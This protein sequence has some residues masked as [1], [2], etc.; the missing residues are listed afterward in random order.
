MLASHDESLINISTAEPKTRKSQEASAEELEDGSNQPRRAATGTASQGSFVVKP[1]KRRFF[2]LFIFCLVT[3]VSGFHW[4]QYSSIAHVATRYYS[5]SNLAMNWMST[6]Y[7]VTFVAFSLPAIL[8]CEQVG[9]RASVLNGATLMSA[10][11]AIKY[12]SASPNAF[13]RLLI[14]QTI[15]ALGQIFLLSVPPRLASVWFPDERVSAATAFG[16]FGNQFGVALGFALPPLFLAAAGDNTRRG[17]DYLNEATT[18]ASLA[19]L[20]LTLAFFKEAPQHAPGLARHAQLEAEKEMRRQQHHQ[21]ALTRLKEFAGELL[22]LARNKGFLALLV[23]YGMVVGTSYAPLTILSQLLRPLFAS[24]MGGQVST[25]ADAVVGFVGL[26]IIVSGML[27]ALAFAA[28]LDA[29]H[30]FKELS[31]T[32]LAAT[33]G[34]TLALGAGLELRCVSLV[35]A[36]SAALGFFVTGYLAIGFE[37]AVEIC[38]PQPEL[39]L[40]CLMNLT[41]QIFGFA[42]TNCASMVV[43]ALGTVAVTGLFGTFFAL[44]L[45]V[46]AFTELELRRQRAIRKLNDI[47][48]ASS[49]HAAAFAFVSAPASAGVGRA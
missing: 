2:V 48:S 15:T 6:V 5:V 4:I 40:A 37:V 20:V 17:L 10:G 33:L 25:N 31:V 21:S 1:S 9:L 18:L 23:A 11:A 3:M 19:T 16:V 27:G 49:R 35:C 30:R 32:L 36:S 41:P 39:L 42:I 47:T 22:A 8:W 24:G 7:M 44:G 38:Y 13:T 34:A 46:T 28:V 12:L 26:L 29:T 14:G 45:L 43:D